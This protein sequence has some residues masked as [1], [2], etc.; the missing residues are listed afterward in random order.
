LDHAPS[1]VIQASGRSIQASNKQ[2]R[3]RTDIPNKKE[4]FKR[5][6]KRIGLIATVKTAQETR[7]TE[8]GLKRN[9]YLK[10]YIIKE[11]KEL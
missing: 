1:N 11:I 2:E 7:K 8:L 4:S 9:N 5:T 10:I 3:L 6:Y